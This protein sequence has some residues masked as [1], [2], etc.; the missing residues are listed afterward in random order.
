LHFLTNERDES[1]ATMAVSSCVT[2]SI[3]SAENLVN[4]INAI[5]ATNV[6]QHSDAGFAAVMKAMSV[7]GSNQ[8]PFDGLPPKFDS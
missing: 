8:I 3:F 4:Y 6:T 2:D 5:E 7:T 1:S